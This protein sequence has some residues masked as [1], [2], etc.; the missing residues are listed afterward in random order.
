MIPAGW[1]NI[2]TQYDTSENTHIPERVLQVLEWP[3]IRDKLAG[4]SASGP[5]KK[6]C[7]EL[8]P[9]PKERIEAQLD[10]ISALK[11]LWL[12]GEA[13]D[14][15]GLSDITSLVVRAEKGGALSIEEL[16]CIRDFASSE[17]RIRKYLR[18]H[19]AEFPA[20]DGEH[21]RFMPLDDLGELLASS[22][23]ERNEL[24]DSYYPALKAFREKIRSSRKEIEKRLHHMLSNHELEAALQEKIFST[25]NDR[26]V[27]LV[28]AGMKG[29]IRGTLHDIS[30][31]GQTLYI[32]PDS[33]ADLNDTV[34]ML[35]K[36]LQA[37]IGS[38]LRDLTGKVSHNAA[39]LACDQEALGY[40]DFLTAAA[41]FSALVRGNRQVVG[42]SAEMVLH[43][44]RHPLLQIMDPE[45]NVANDVELGKKY[46]GLLISGANTGGKTVLL[47]TIGL[48]ALFTLYGLH[49]PAG[50]DSRI[51][52]FTTILADIGDDQN[53]S[54]SLSTFSGQIVAI[55]E[56]LARADEHS[57]IMVDEI[58][59]GTNP[60]QG[61]ALAQ[62]IL[63]ALIDTG[64]ALVVTTHYP[65]LKE[66][67]AADPRFENAS[68]SFD[69]DT[70]KPTYLLKTGLPGVSY[71]LEIASTY[72]LSPS[73]I[74]R[75]RGLLD[76]RDI[77][78]ES[79]IEKIQEHRKKMDQ[80]NDALQAQKEQIEAFRLE[81][82][83]RENELR[84]KTS[85]LKHKQG[86][87]FLREL[88]KHRDQVAARIREL[89]QAGLRESGKIQEEIIEREAE[90]SEKL[91]GLAEE[92]F[93]GTYGEADPG[94]LKKGDAVFVVPLEQEGVIDEIDHGSG[95]LTVVLGGT[96]RTQIKIGEIMVPLRKT[97]AKKKA[98]EEK[99][100]EPVVEKAIPLTVQ[101][102]YNTIDL[103]GKR[104]EEALRA[105]DAGLD[106]MS[107]TGISSAVIIHGHGTGALKEAV[108]TALRTSPYIA[109]F[110]PGDYGEGGD[111][112]SVVILR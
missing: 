90:V 47:K 24:N 58:I 77:S 93:S 91:S 64:C 66:L 94:R 74:N 15:S 46:R 35:E 54:Q 110:R 23:T 18:E 42:D 63:E 28:R 98:R 75:S 69:L 68:V 73:I 45:R 31:S 106:Y 84:R 38:I 25:R 3:V 82:A 81:L 4:L 59:V 33:I 57:L 96:I 7:S 30:A 27:L 29:R 62:A 100:K 112:V 79:L 83:E 1:H 50:P 49:A 16:A 102:R 101:T 13:P 2:M 6:Y 22:I 104:V 10:K 41:R 32:E 5:G 55:G 12:R 76:G 11:D 86:I 26:Y 67:A 40:C 19:R 97:A 34:L 108:R 39:A 65:E 71:A 60:R 51:G 78:V 95:K 44:A 92:R 109:D 52:R 14:F 36:E 88:Q 61:A 72:G 21:D 87:E 89:Q 103:R 85:E 17:R 70:L 111:G 9:L 8:R 43:S 105:L 37:E 56:M 48:C 80:E 20:L 53:L 99:R 107:R